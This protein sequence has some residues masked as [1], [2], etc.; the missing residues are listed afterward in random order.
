MDNTLKEFC[1]IYMLLSAIIIKQSEDLV[2]LGCDTVS[3]GM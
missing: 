2:I 3:L 1:Y